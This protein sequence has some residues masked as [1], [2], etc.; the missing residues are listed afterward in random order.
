MRD[1]L[2][3]RLHGMLVGELLRL[4]DGRIDFDFVE[5]YRDNVN[6]PTLSQ[7]FVEESGGVANRER[8]ATS[9]FV[10]RF[11]SN[12]LPEGQLRSYLAKLAGLS[13]YRE[14]E[15][16]ELLGSDLPGA[17]EV[18][19]EGQ[20]TDFS[21]SH[22]H[23]EDDTSNTLRFSLAGVQLKFSAI[24]RQR[25]GLTIPAYG[26]G[27]DWIVKLPSTQHKRIV[28]NEY[29]VMSMARQIGIEIPDIKLVPI[30]EIE[31]LP[32]EVSDLNEPNALGVRRFDR[33][34]GRRL[35]M[36]DFAQA[37]AQRPIDKYN[38]Q[39]NYTDLVKL[40]AHVCTEDDVM[41]FAKRLMYNAIV[42][43]GDMHLKNWSLL[44]PD[45]KTP[46][47]SPAYDLLCTTVYIPD[48]GMALALG[49]AKRWSDLT[50][51]DFAA[52]AEGADVDRQT[53][54]D[55]AI[56]TA[57]RF[58][59]GWKDFTQSLPVDDILKRRIERQIGTCPA[60]TAAVRH[61]LPGK[62]KRL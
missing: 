28:E 35:H 62:T 17:V 10:P 27:G 45:G 29:S 54:V 58:F 9:G 16:L 53:F 61:T 25:G 1:S 6:R 51:K 42:G 44:Y 20:G 19:R 55:A 11:F 2:N 40:V 5:E 21:R 52:V 38:P 59:D 23:S 37:L 60:I 33:A 8:A 24:Q 50:L 14:F 39:L 36:E 13:E 15:L 41:D 57:V 31:G 30:T 49:S 7:S 22:A 12:L 47:L 46:E 48:D 3:V 26:V 32:A 18:T 43:N 34:S 4:D 56:N